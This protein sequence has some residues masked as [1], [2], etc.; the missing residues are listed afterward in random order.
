[1]IRRTFV[2]SAFRG[3]PLVVLLSFAMSECAFAVVIIQ[4]NHVGFVVLLY[5][6]NK[7]CVPFI[8]PAQSCL[9]LTVSLHPCDNPLWVAQDFAPPNKT[10]YSNGQ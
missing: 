8:R 2:D 5:T 6:I 7:Y 3:F 9:T 10:L 4:F 1:M